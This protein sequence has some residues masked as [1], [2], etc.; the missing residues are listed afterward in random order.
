MLNMRF[1]IQELPGRFGNKARIPF[2]EYSMISAP[3]RSPTNMLI[4]NS[5]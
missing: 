4:L 5:A 2:I 3:V 1:D